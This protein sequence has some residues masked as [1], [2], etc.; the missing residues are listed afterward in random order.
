MRT[1]L[2]AA[3][4]V[5]AAL[6]ASAREGPPPP[7]TGQYVDLSTVGVPVIEAGKL[8]NYIFVR[9]RLT[10]SGQVDAAALRA[11]EPYFRDALVRMTHRTPF[12]LPGDGIRLDEAALKAA[13]LR[14]AQAIAGPGAVTGVTITSAMPQRRAGIAQ[15]TR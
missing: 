13:M 9:M 14:Q 15:P 1:V 6:P 8:R 7:S 12:N 2:L 11:K 10:L 5:L 3:V 4:L